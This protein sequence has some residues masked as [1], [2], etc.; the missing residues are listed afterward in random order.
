MLALSALTAAGAAAAELRVA[1]YHTELSRE[2]PGLMLRDIAAEEAQVVALR[3]VIE[4]VDPDILVLGG[5]DFDARGVALGA[6]N[7]ALDRPYAHAVPLRPNRGIAT[8]LDLDGDGRLGGP[9]DA[10]A[11]GRFAGQGGMALLSRFPP[12]G[13]ARSLNEVLWRDLP[14]SLMVDHAGKPGASGLGAGVQR[15]SSGGHWIVPLAIADGQEV[16]IMAF[17]ASP[18]VFDG[19]EDRNGRRNHDEI[20]MWQHLLDGRLPVVPPEGA[21]VLAG[22]ANADP[23]DGEARR[24]GI[25][26]LLSDP[27]FR[28]PKPLSEGGAA[29]ANPGHAGTPGLDTVDWEE[30][31]PGNLRVDYVLPSARMEV[32]AAGVFWPAPEAPLAETAARASRHRL[33]WVDLNF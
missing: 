16:A 4:A 26:G 6:F 13:A 33:V 24:A 2:G 25:R 22:T 9:G 15:L 5:M 31:E 12:A 28:D 18:P 27:R 3:R 7:A 21:C 32:V 1:Y 17:H 14:D 30:P 10:Q 23:F 11:Y 8:G 29:H 19:P 20:R